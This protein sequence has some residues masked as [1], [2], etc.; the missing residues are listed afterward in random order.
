MLTVDHHSV[1]YGQSTII[2]DLNLGVGENEIV[3]VVGRNGMGKTTLMKSLIGMTPSRAG[4]VALNDTDLT[5]MKSYQRVRAGLGFV[6]QGR[7]IF[8]TLTVRENI[9]TGL[10]AVGEKKVPADLYELFPV[11]EE[12]QHRRGGNLSGGQQQQLAI[13][14]ALATRPKVLLLDEPTEGIQPSIIQDMA[15]TLK[16]IRDQRGLS[17]VVSEQVLSF[18]MDIA[19]R[20]LVI[21]KG[22]IV[23]EEAGEGADQDKIAGY[24]SV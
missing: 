9:E 23:H 6:P 7:M 14:R 1:A 13:A 15:R 18:V 2:R 24:L 8:P 3:A 22:E 20:I 10:A 16:R 4:R 11:L 12:M 17:I 5:A 21:E 19:D